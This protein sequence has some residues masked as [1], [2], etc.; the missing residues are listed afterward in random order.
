M[1]SKNAKVATKEE[2]QRF[3]RMAE[4]GCIACRLQG[5]K[6]PLWAPEI[7]HLIDGMKRRGHSDTI[8]LCT[9]HHRGVQSP[10]MNLKEMSRF[11]GPSLY[12]DGKAFKEVY[13][14][15]DELLKLQNKLLALV[16]A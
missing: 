10:G 11:A 15:D 3:E 8:C 2:K 5:L 1:H 7:H 4:I 14:K 9:W 16:T 12:H 13:G 6:K